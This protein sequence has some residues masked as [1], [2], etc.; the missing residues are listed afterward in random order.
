[1]L[2]RQNSSEYIL[3]LGVPKHDFHSCELPPPATYRKYQPK[4]QFFATISP[5]LTIVLYHL[6]TNVLKI[7]FMHNNLKFKTL[8]VL[9]KQDST[10][11]N[12]C[13]R[14]S[15]IFLKHVFGV[16]T[17]KKIPLTGDTESLNRC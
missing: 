10:S 15:Q 4:D 14:V 11:A 3:V 7:Y 6:R 8:V 13:T 2:R 12:R 1:M 16:I 5:I 17:I 9:I